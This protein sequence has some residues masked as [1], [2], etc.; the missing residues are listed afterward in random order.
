M[1]ID[2]TFTIMDTLLVIILGS[3]RLRNAIDVI[4]ALRG[5]GMMPKQLLD[6]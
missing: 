4:K 5:Y 1:F 6:C 2:F 3:E